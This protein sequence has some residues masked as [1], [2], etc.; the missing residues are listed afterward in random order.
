MLLQ[1]RSG[2]VPELIQHTAKEIAGAFYDMNRTDQFR[3]QAGTQ[4][5]FVKMH[6]KD[7]IQTAIDSLVGVMALPGTTEHV[8]QE[9]YDA[10]TEFNDR[11]SEKT[12]E[13][14]LRNLQ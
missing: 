3:A 13:L 12:P 6:W 2:E 10:I 7:H 9:I 4:R 8:K 14:S 11:A 5:R 1:I